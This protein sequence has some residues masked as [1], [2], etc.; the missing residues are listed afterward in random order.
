MDCKK[1]FFY[2]P[3]TY[4]YMCLL[5]FRPTSLLCFITIDLD[6]RSCRRYHKLPFFSLHRKVIISFSILILEACLDVVSV[7]NIKMKIGL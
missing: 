3:N 7:Q 4:T 1:T 6:R 2:N 5:T